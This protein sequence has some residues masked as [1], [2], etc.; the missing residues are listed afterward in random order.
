[1]Q[2]DQHKRL[3]QAQ[4]DIWID[5][6]VTKLYLQCLEWSASQADEIVGN[7][8]QI[9][10]SNNDRSM[11]NIHGIMGQRIGLITASNP[12]NLFNTHEMI[13]IPKEEEAE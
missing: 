7:G 1:M 9:D 4:F 5:S 3:T 6:P 11:N 10:S 12:E 2:E 8:S 13:E